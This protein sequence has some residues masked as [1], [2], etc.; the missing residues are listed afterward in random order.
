[1]SEKIEQIEFLD[2]YLKNKLDWKI[3][4]PVFNDEGEWIGQQSG[5]DFTNLEIYEEYNIYYCKIFSNELG[6]S[7]IGVFVLPETY[8][9]FKTIV[10]IL[11]GE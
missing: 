6:H 3:F 8:E 9:K 5:D 7:L 10:D 11:L 4:N 2:E 1:M